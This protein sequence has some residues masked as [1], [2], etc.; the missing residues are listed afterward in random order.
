MTQRFSYSLEDKSSGSPSTGEPEFLAVGKLR[1]PHGVHGEMVMSV[2]T[3]S[4][5]RMQAGID[6]YVGESQQ[7]LQVRSVRWHQQD[8]LI[9]FDGYPDREQ[10]G[11]LRNK[12]VQVRVADLPALEEGEYYLH[13]ILG[14]QVIQE[15]EPYLIGHVVEITETGANDVYLVR[16]HDGSEFL[17]PAIETVVL[18]VDIENREMLVRL[19]PGLLPNQ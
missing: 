11:E 6:I 7:L 19:L 10:V 9:A 14:I 18:K 5:E 16:R 12:I 13:Q 8:I 17:L 15:E 1:R 3:D 2:W 4:P